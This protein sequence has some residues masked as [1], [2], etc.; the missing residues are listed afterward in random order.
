MAFLGKM[1]CTKVM[2]TTRQRLGTLRHGM[3]REES[4]DRPQ[5]QRAGTVL[6][7]VPSPGATPS[8]Y[9]IAAERWR[10]I[11][12]GLPPG[13]CRVLELLRDGHSHTAIADHLGI[14]RKVIQRLLEH[15][16]EHL[17]TP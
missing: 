11:I 17:E 1:A 3:N 5:P 13:H 12:K 8:Q 2:E 9:A 16:Q 4:L 7:S 10:E 15:L 6:E 14:H